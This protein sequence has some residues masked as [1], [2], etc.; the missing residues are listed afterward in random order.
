MSSYQ[1]YLEQDYSI[2]EP[3]QET[4]LVAS[5]SY[6]HDPPIEPPESPRTYL[7]NLMTHIH[8]NILSSDAVLQPRAEIVRRARHDTYRL[9]MDA[10]R[11]VHNSSRRSSIEFTPAIL[12]LG[13]GARGARAQGAVLIQFQFPRP[14]G[15][16]RANCFLLKL[17][18]SGTG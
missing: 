17:R 7:F 12:G 4:R 10:A 16:L 9:S 14:E 6:S 18:V 5:P 13:F 15:M 11:R 8:D 2:E 1:E 3:R